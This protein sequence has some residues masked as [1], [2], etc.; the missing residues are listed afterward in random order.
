MFGQSAYKKFLYF[1][2]S[3]AV[4]L[5]KVTN[6]KRRNIELLSTKSPTNV[7]MGMSDFN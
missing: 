1:P 3:F 4:N 2:L 7:Y 6:F 5:K